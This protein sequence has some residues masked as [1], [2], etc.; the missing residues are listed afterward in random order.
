MNPY[1]IEPY[2]PYNKSPRKKHWM[3]IAE[4]EALYARIIAE[5]QARQ[6]K[7]Q[8]QLL[9]IRH[10]AENVAP[11]AQATVAGTPIAAAAGAGGVPESPFFNRV[12]T[13]SFT[14]VSP[15]GLA[16]FTVV[17][18]NNS[19]PTYVDVNWNMGDGTTD[20]GRV[21]SHTYASTG[22]YIIS[23]TASS[24]TRTSATSSI[25]SA[26]LPTLVI[27]FTGTPRFGQV[28]FAVQFTNTTLNGSSYLW[29]FGTGSTGPTTSSQ[30]SGSTQSNPIFTYTT[31]SKLYTITLQATGSFGQQTS[32]SSFAYISASL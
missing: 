15:T 23:C 8:A 1:L 21:I 9:E 18:T 12:V 5:E 25:V 4:E 20:T 6:A 29:S 30:S 26:S 7:F 17:C 22:S 11:T 28:P 2:N 10:S 19:T 27:G 32:T 31:G 24:D 16:P 14:M 13:G 3:E